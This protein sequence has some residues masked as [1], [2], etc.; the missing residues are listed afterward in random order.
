ML[1]GRDVERAAVAAVLDS[2][3]DGRGG[4][5]CCSAIPGSGKSALLADAVARAEGMT[6]LRT[7]GV[8]SES[9][10]AFAALQRLLRP[11]MR[12]VDRLPEPQARALRA[13]F[14]EADGSLG[15][16]F[17][18]F[19][20][21]LSLL[22]EASEQA[23]VLAVVDDAHWLDDAS[24]AALLFVARRLEVERVGLLF[25]ARVGDVRRFDSGDLP[26]WRVGGVDADAAG[27]L[28][29]ERTSGAVAPRGPGR[30]GRRHGRQPAGPGR[31]RRGAAPRSAR[32]HGAPAGPAAAD[33]GRRASV[34][35]PLPP[36]VR[37]GADGA[38]WWP[39]AT[40]PAG[41][42]RPRGAAGALGA[43]DERMDDAERSGLLAVRR[44]RRGA[45]ASAGAL[46]GLRG[47][48]EHRTATRPRRPGRRPE[49]TTPTAGPG[50]W[51]PPLDRAGRRRSWRHSTAP[52]SGRVRA[53]GTRPRPRRGSG[54][55]SC[56]SRRGPRRRLYLAAFSAWLVAQP[57]GPASWPTPASPWS[58]IRCVRADLR[59]LHGHLECNIGSLDA[60]LRM[61]LRGRR[62]GRA[63]RRLAGRRQ[64]AMLGAALAA[65][66]RP[67]GPPVPTRRAAARPW[68]RTPRPATGASPTCTRG[69][70]RGVR[71]GTGPSRGPAS[72]GPSRWRDCPT[73]R[74]TTA[75]PT[76]ASPPGTR[77]RRAASAAAGPAARRRP[78]RRRA[79]M[80]LHAL[81]RRA[82]TEIATGRWRARPPGPP[83]RCRSQRTPVSRGWPRCRRRSSR[84]WRLSAATTEPSTL[85]AV[86]ADRRRR[87]PWGCSTAS[88]RPAALGARP[89]RRPLAAG[90]HHLAQIS[91]P[92]VRR[93]AALD[94]IEAAVRAGRRDIAGAWLDEL[95]AFAEAVGPAWARRGRRAR[96]GAAGRRHR[97]RG[98]LRAGAAAP[99]RPL[100]VPD[101]ARTQLAY[102]EFLRRARRRVDAREHLRA[103]LETFEDLGAGPWA[104]RAAQELR[105]SGETAR[106][107]DVY[108]APT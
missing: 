13:A 55:P 107:R 79:H 64:L 44:R 48:H 108:A 85:A 22:A 101:R 25:A 24:A 37:A 35:R 61:V 76:W 70:R 87:T 96:P 43:D 62:G 50:T 47:G 104:E 94:R 32:R 30:A 69:S 10:L 74:T 33:R 52:P 26:T 49:A 15:D 89:G 6:V 65:V 67:V 53:A 17:L 9:P 95:A 75:R 66:R 59:R 3:R 39:P 20:A 38:C 46:G 80:V 28:L 100:R 11:V 21:A 88:C 68:D 99:R 54:P 71:G 78:H 16:R 36:P 18:V 41:W 81:T 91:L 73:R 8:E 103:A 60:G 57:V 56:P 83:S 90:L 63:G 5:S 31:A 45:A 77:R 92:S 82:F 58:P 4:A 98:A 51:P 29:A 86:R 42:R 19:L 40:T 84:C 34:P 105:A 12:C 14:G 27:R 7:Q 2:A 23:P 93:L 72:A 1:Q 106:R 97:G 102:G